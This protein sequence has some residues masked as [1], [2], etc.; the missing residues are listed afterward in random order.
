MNAVAKRPIEDFVPGGILSS[1]TPHRWTM[2]HT[3]SRCSAEIP[4]D[5]VPLEVYSPDS[6]TMWLYCDGCIA[7]GVPE[8]AKH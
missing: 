5:D 6:I 7:A 1:D 2:G 4:E 8:E 3:C